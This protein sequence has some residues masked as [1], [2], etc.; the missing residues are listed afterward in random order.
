MGRVPGFLG[1]FELAGTVP[2]DMRGSFNPLIIWYPRRA[3]NHRL[4][5]L[6]YL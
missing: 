1:N 5:A 6:F 2:A 3:P 4:L